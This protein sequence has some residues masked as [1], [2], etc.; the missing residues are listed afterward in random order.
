M[1]KYVVTLTKDERDELTALTS[2]G[3]HQSQKNSQCPYS[4]ELRQ[5]RISEATL[6]K[7]GNRPRAQ[8]KHEKNRPC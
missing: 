4:V 7:R 2:K 3:K 1:E 5:G 6:E 8:C